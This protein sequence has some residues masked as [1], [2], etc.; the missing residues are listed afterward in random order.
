LA[1]FDESF[2]YRKLDCFLEVEN[3]DFSDFESNNLADRA[4]REYWD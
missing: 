3:D 2:S 4:V 1:S